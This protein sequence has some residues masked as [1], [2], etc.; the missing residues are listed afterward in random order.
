MK[1][2]LM[3]SV[4]AKFKKVEYTSNSFFNILSLN[5]KRKDYELS[6]H[7]F[8]SGHKYC[9]TYPLHNKTNQQQQKKK[10]CESSIIYVNI[11]FLSNTS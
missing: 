4:I 8:S 5:K 6:H 7:R 10:R 3:F 11:L 9:I 1:I 2:C